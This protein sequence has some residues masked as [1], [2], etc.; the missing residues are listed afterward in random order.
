MLRTTALA[1][2]VAVLA[3]VMLATPVA[4]QQS[5]SFNIGRFSLRSESGRVPGDTLVEN[6]AATAPFALDFRVSDFD[7][8]TVGVEWLFPLGDFLEGGVGAN[9]YSRTVPS[10]YRDL[11]NRNGSEIMQDLRLRTVPITATVRFLPRGRR[12]GVQPYV[13]AGVGVIP[14]RYSETGD[15]A[16]PAL[17]VFRSNYVGS[18]TAVGPVIFGGLRVPFSRKFALGGEIRYQKADAALNSSLG[19]TGDRLDLGGITYQANLI[20]RF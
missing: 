10:F 15:F 9:Y 11:V 3:V 13:G 14:W 4:A 20:F 19:F 6:L 16:D 5:L 18:G 7:N 2:V 17:D 1:T 8:T 12:A